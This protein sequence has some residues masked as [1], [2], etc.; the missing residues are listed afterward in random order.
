[1]ATDA[2]ALDRTL[3]AEAEVEFLRDENA[4]LARAL[5]LE[6]EAHASLRTVLG[7]VVWEHGKKALAHTP[8]LKAL[9]K[10]LLPR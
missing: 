1:M 9:L 8:R 2:A 4:R 3:R 6:R 5:E 10:R 7:K